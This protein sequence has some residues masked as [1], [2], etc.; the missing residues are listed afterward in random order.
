M[1]ENERHSVL[2]RPHF[3]K[4]ISPALTVPRLGA[5]VTAGQ[6]DSATEQHDVPPEGLGRLVGV[7]GLRRLVYRSFAKKRVATINGESF[8]IGLSPINAWRRQNV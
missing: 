3:L 7:G 5:E 1:V 6:A 2:I 8:R 4:Y